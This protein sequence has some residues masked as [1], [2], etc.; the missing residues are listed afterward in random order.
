ML[1]EHPEPALE[2]PESETIVEA[3]KGFIKKQPASKRRRLWRWA[4]FG[5]G[6]LLA[7]ALILGLALHFALSKRSGVPPVNTLKTPGNVVNT[8]VGGPV[9]AT[10]FADPAVIE[11]NGTYYAFATNKYVNPHPDQVNIQIAVSTDFSSWTLTGIDALP[12][13]GN[14]STGSFVWAPDV[15]QLDDGTFV[16]YYS[17]KHAIKSKHHCVGVATS[18]DIMGPYTPGAQPL[19]CPLSAGGAIDPDGFQ[20]ADGTRYLIYKID[21]NSLNNITGTD[22][23]T[24]LMLQQ[25]SNDDGFTLIGGP[26]QLL[27]RTKADGPLIEAPSLMRSTSGKSPVYVLFFSSNVFTTFH[28][29]V[30]YATSTTGVKGPYIRSTQPLLRTGDDSGRLFG[31]G[32]L[33]VGVGGQKVVFHSGYDGGSIVRQLW[34]GQIAVNGTTHLPSPSP[35]SFPTL[36][37]LRH[38]S[39]SP[40]HVHPPPPSSL[41]RSHSGSDP[42]AYTR[43]HAHRPLPTGSAYLA[44]PR[45]VVLRAR[46]GGWGRG[47]DGAEGGVG[48]GWV[49]VGGRGERGEWEVEAEVLGS[50][51]ELLG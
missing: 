15:I 10:N 11:V 26:T 14:W 20:D 21:G 17:A 38:P 49:V 34:T 29:D 19:V 45:S 42:T 24:P 16:M 9:V 28:Y 18:K 41:R 39:P 44:R 30:S 3:E 46:A 5:C 31:P 13:V 33:D 51:V 35:A 27:D 37:F 12:H 22:N 6:T 23:P 47:V 25:V 2:P 43:I 32:G 8:W 40:L 36:T 4:A 50:G 1:T 7:I 48:N